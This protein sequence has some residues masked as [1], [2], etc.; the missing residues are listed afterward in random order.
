MSNAIKQDAKLFPYTLHAIVIH[1][2]DAYGGH[3]FNFIKDHKNNRWLKFND[4][5]VSKVAES[6]VF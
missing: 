2:G 5:S 6:E 4:S 3:F 1:S